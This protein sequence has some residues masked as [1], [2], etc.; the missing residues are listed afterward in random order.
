ESPGMLPSISFF[1]NSRER[2]AVF[3]FADATAT[4]SGQETSC[5]SRTSSTLSFCRSQ[6]WLMTTTSNSLTSIGS[7]L[8]AGIGQGSSRVTRKMG[9]RSRTSP[10]NNPG[11]SVA[12]NQIPSLILGL[13]VQV[14]PF[15]VRECQILAPQ[16]HRDNT[17]PNA[18]GFLRRHVEN[19]R[20]FHAGD[21]RFFRRSGL[22]FD[23]GR[24]VR[25]PRQPRQLSGQLCDGSLECHNPLFQFHRGHCPALP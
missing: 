22:L 24:A 7:S 15:G 20:I 21:Q 25:R 19:E 3:P 1:R 18:E 14:R 16:F 23:R 2:I 4:A 9:Q 11:P 17:R 10:W 13:Q 6:L 5:A 8:S 12:S